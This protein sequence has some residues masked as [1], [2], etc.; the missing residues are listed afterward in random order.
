V[1]L[2]IKKITSAVFSIIL[3]SGAGMASAH[4]DAS[5]SV[6]AAIAAPDRPEAEVKRDAARQPAKV[7]IF[8]TIKPG[9]M[10]ADL[11]AG[12]GYFTRLISGI[13][14]EHGQVIA[15][16]PPDWVEQY[17][18]IAPALAA[19]GKTRP[20]VKAVTAKFDNLGFADESLDVVTMAL[21]YH[22][23]VLSSADTG[24]MNKE[25][26]AALKPGGVLL[27]TDHFAKDGSGDTLINAQHRID[28]ALVRKGV[29]AAGFTLE[30]QSDALRFDTDDR[31]KNVFDPSVRG[32]TDRFVYRF[33][34][35]KQPKL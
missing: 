19:L 27:I 12:G 1:D 16:N 32:K 7:L 14:G 8:S 24:A 18:S 28:A 33:R 10:V 30:A 9:N 3:L 29:E 21:I 17:K 23:V 31:T 34:K 13:V 2:V 26:Y 22:D 11:G 15:Q 20:N 6:A 35:A 25:I 5:K 4:G